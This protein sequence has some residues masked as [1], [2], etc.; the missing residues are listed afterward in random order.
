MLLMMLFSTLNITI[1]GRVKTIALLVSIKHLMIYRFKNLI[2][3]NYANLVYIEN[4]SYFQNKL[5]RRL[6]KIVT[7]W[8]YD[9]FGS[10]FRQ[11][12]VEEDILS[13]YEDVTGKNSVHPV[14]CLDIMDSSLLINDV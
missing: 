11:K 8:E 14:F 13:A 12:S 7:F 10:N 9:L 6:K 4:M 1:L 5:S 2:R 3:S